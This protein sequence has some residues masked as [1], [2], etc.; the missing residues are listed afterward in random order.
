MMLAIVEALR[1]IG[2]SASIQELDEKVIEQEG[3]TEAEQSYV[4]QRDENR[5]R[6][7]YYL[8]WART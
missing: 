3:V 2:E 8:A 7:N 1:S 5:P 6:V 4:M